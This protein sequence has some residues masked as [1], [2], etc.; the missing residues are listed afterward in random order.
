MTS[1]W[2][3]QKHLDLCAK[4]CETYSNLPAVKE[5]PLDIMFIVDYD[6]VKNKTKVLLQ[7]VV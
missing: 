3:P 6:V 1:S 7:T 2:K 4:N 5:S